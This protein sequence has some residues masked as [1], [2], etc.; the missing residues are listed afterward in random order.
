MLS[1]MW[2]K[3]GLQRT[4]SACESFKKYS[5]SVFVLEVERGM[6]QAPDSQVASWERAYVASRWQR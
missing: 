5:I 1:K 6:A 2:V 4:S 3:S